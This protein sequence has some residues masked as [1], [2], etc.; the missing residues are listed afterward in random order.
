MVSDE[1]YLAAGILGEPAGWRWLI[2]QGVDAGGK[3]EGQVGGDW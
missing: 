3:L 2:V 1:P